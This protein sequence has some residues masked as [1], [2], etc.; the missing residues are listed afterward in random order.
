MSRHPPPQASGASASSSRE[1]S[2]YTPAF[3]AM[4][5]DRQARDKDPY[6]SSDEYE[7]YLFE[8]KGRRKPKRE[9]YEVLEWRRQAAVILDSPELLLMFSQS[10]NDSVTG[11][12][13]YFTRMLCGYLDEDEISELYDQKKL[14]QVS[15]VKK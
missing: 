2:T 12:R 13:H 15:T 10:R 6:A 8:Y 14:T 5:Q 11:T 1:S 7:E 4:M 3:T 9:S